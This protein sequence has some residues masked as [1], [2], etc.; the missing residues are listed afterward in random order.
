[1]SIRRLLADCSWRAL[2]PFL[3]LTEA[4]EMDILGANPHSVLAQ[5][6]SMLKNGNRRKEGAP[7]AIGR[8]YPHGYLYHSKNIT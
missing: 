5:K 4:E 6:I 8:L 3:G 7:L 2:S 1:M